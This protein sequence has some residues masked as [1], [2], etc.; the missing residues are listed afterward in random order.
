MLYFIELNRIIIYKI[1]V[2]CIYICFSEI[3]ILEDKLYM[4]NIIDVI[5]NYSGLKLFLCVINRLKVL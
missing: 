5:I 2:D 1:Y 4:D 3:F